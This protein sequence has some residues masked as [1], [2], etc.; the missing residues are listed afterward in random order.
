MPTMVARLLDLADG[1]LQSG[2]RSSAARRRA[3]ST[4]YYAV[5]H[6]LA[7][8]CADGLVPAAGRN[9]DEY[10]RVY[11][12]LDHGTLKSAF[13]TAPLADRDVFRNLGDLIVRLQSERHR[14]DYSPP[15]ANVF[16]SE[17]TEKLIAQA[18]QVISGIEALETADRRTLAVCLLFKARP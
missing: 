16:S 10:A 13:R 11:R 9:S 6:A 18:R 3:V 8:V 12:S 2:P 1:L 4:A 17:Q 14:A 15:V 7:K 5:F